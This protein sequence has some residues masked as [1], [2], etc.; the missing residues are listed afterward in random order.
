[1]PNRPWSYVAVG[2]LIVLAV[3]IAWW[4]VRLLRDRRR[5]PAGIPA[6]PPAQDSEADLLDSSHVGFAP[7]ID[8]V[9]LPPAPPSANRK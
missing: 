9:T 2:A 6:A 7:L 3:V 8:P 5:A 4:V 1:M